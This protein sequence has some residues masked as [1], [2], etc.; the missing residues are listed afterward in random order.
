[1]GVLGLLLC[2]AKVIVVGGSAGLGVSAGDSEGSYQGGSSG[3]GSFEGESCGGGSYQG[4]S[5]LRR[6]SSAVM[7]LQALLRPL[8]WVAPAISVLPRRLE[9]FV[10]S[11]VPL[12]AGYCGE[13]VTT[14]QG[15]G[16]SQSRVA[17]MDHIANNHHHNNKENSNIN[18]K[19]TNDDNNL[20]TGGTGTGAGTGADFGDSNGGS[21]NVTGTRARRPSPLVE[22]QSCRRARDLLRRWG[23]GI[24]SH[25]TPFHDDLLTPL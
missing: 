16:Q 5:G 12:L 17:S 23:D 15:Q 1:M 18:H 3:E 11:P 21:G 2:E 8:E 9:E 4:G 10:E 7:G 19:E 22:G 13:D 20:R 6:V 25:D 14:G 24:S